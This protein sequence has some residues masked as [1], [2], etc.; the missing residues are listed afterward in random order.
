MD[1]AVPGEADAMPPFEPLDHP[2]QGRTLSRLVDLVGDGLVL[3]GHALTQVT[4]RHSR[5]EPGSGH[6]Q[7][8]SVQAAGLFDQHRR[9]EAPRVFE[10]AQAALGLGWTFVG[11]D[12]LWSA[13]RRCLKSG[14]D[15]NTGVGWLVVRQLGLIRP[16]LGLA[17][18]S[19]WSGW[20][21]W[22]SASP[23]GHHACVRSGGRLPPD[24][25]STVS[26]AQR[27]PLVPPQALQRVGLASAR[28]V[29]RWRHMRAAGRC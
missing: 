13:Q 7:Q 5:H 27:Q 24:G 15:H 22:A 19:P 20:G 12:H 28:V 21:W 3:A 6:H 23:G 8:Q 17:S 11:L 4:W 14:S 26:P 2:P 29:C 9:D 16:H 18:A 10:N 25:R 1:R